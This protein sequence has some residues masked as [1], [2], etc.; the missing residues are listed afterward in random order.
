[1][2]RLA[3]GSLVRH[4]FPRTTNAWALTEDGIEMEFRSG[5][6]KACTTVTT[7]LLTDTSYP[8]NN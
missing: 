3:N 2:Q 4:N 1:M 6:N 7:L 5:A 8:C